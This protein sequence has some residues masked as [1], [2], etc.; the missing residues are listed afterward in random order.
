MLAD[1]SRSAAWSFAARRWAAWCCSS[2]GAG[3]RLRGAL[4]AGRWWRAW[5]ARSCSAWRSCNSGARS[6]TGSPSAAHRALD[7]ARPAVE[8]EPARAASLSGPGQ[9]RAHRARA[10]AAISRRSLWPRLTRAD[11]APAA[12][13][14]C[15]PGAR[16]Q[17]GEPAPGDRRHREAAGEDSPSSPSG[18]ARW[19]LTLGRIVVGKDDVLER[20]L[21]GILANG[22]V[23]VEDY[24]GLAKTLIGPAPGPGARPRL[25]AHPVHARPAAERHHR[26]AFSTTSARAGSSSAPARSSPICC[27]PTR[28]TAPRPRRRRRCWRPCRNRR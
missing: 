4:V 7:A 15:S 17:P 12:A 24:P 14:G 26:A 8:P 27:S 3:V 6:S 11:A 18:S 9:R 1:R 20:I 2:R 13:P 19:W 10:A 16:A 5:P 21:A 28:S 22:H 23:L 25:P